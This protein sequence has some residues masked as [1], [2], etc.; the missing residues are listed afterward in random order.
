MKI[1]NKREKF[2]AYSVVFL[3]CFWVVISL[4]ISPLLQKNDS[5]NKEIQFTAA[6]LKK[7]K[8][9]LNN[10][11]RILKKYG[12]DGNYVLSSPGIEFNLLSELESA[13]KLYGIT[14]IDVRPQGLFNDSGSSRGASVDL[15]AEG[16]IQNFVKFIYAI[17]NSISMFNISRFQLKSKPNSSLLE[18][19]FSISQTRI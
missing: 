9:L 5:L 7:Y 3:I 15:R 18:G 1:F 10:K 16:S 13:A 12:G 17:E 6:K 4:F 8:W 2:I 14:I 11:E 19:T